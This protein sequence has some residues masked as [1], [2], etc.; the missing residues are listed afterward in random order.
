[1]YAKVAHCA[2]SRHLLHSEQVP[3]VPWKEVTGT[4]HRMTVLWRLC[5]PRT[6]LA[7]IRSGWLH[8]FIS[9]STC[10]SLP[11]TSPGAWL[12]LLTYLLINWWESSQR[13]RCCLRK[14][15]MPVLKTLSLMSWYHFPELGRR[16]SSRRCKMSSWPSNSYA[17]FIA[18]MVLSVKLWKPP[19]CPWFGG[20]VK[21]VAVSSA[22]GRLFCCHYKEKDME[23]EEHS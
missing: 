9:W 15:R 5:F 11:R 16:C 17:M 6:H 13:I 4:F 2:L 7:S 3:T 1:M 10:S 20:E 8:Q 21:L 12:V 22:Q 23:C 19:K 14:S 18:S